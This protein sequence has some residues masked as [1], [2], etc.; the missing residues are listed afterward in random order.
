[1]RVFRPLGQAIAH[2]WPALVLVWVV[3]LVAVTML[4][5][6]WDSVV[7]DG[8][9]AF[10]PDDAPSLL[11]EGVYADAFSRNF[12]GS[13]IIVVARRD[14]RPQGLVEPADDPDHNDRQFIAEVLEPRLRALALENGWM[15]PEPDAPAANA[16]PDPDTDTAPNTEIAA[17]PVPLVDKI[18]SFTDPQYGPLLD[19]RD[20]KATLVRISLTTDYTEKVNAPLIEAVQRL[21][22]PAVE[23]SLRRAGQIPAG[24]DLYLSGPAV[25]GNDM[26]EAADESG[27]AT[28][29]ATVVLVVGLLI[30]IYRAPVLALI[31][32]ITVFVGVNIALHLLALLARLG[33]VNLFSGIEIYVTVVMYGAGVDYCMFLMARYKEEL[34]AGATF[35]EAIAESIH[36]VG[37]ALAASAGTTI[38]G[39]GMMV[40]AEFGKFRQAGVAMSLSLAVVLAA[41]LTF[42]PAL[43][44]LFGKWAFWPRIGRERPGRAAGWISPTRVM[45]RLLQTRLLRS[46]WDIVALRITRRPVFYLVTTAAVMAPLAVV[47]VVFHDRLTYGL[48]DELPP[49]RLSVLG[50]AAV[51]DHFPAGE[52]GPVTV[53]I[54]NRGFDFSATDSISEVGKL[55]NALWERREELGIAD[56]RSL[57]APFGVLRLEGL[58]ILRRRIMTNVAVQ[59][60]AYYVSDIGPD[61]THVTRLDIVLHDDPFSRNSIVH[62]D[63]L[64]DA[65]RQALPDDLE[66]SQLNFIGATASIR[67]LKTVTGRD[68]IRIDLL[69]MAGVFF[70]L[71]WLLR[72][73]AVAAYLIVTVFFSYLVTLGATFAVFWWLSPAE[74]AGLDWKVPLFLFT[75]L[76][77]VGEDYNIYLVTRV[78]EEQRRRGGVAGVTVGLARTGGIISSCGIIMAGTFGSLIFGTLAGMVQLGFALAFGVVLDTFIVRPILVPAWLVLVNNGTFGPVW[79]RRLGAIRAPAQVQPS[80]VQPPARTP[81][82]MLSAIRSPRKRKPVK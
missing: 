63:R 3:A 32:L 10:L 21:L 25:V 14:S 37:A 80:P 31:P 42:T 77:A 78:E 58:S 73:P 75:I 46:F 67:D 82:R 74:F 64:E 53:L 48:L 17:L 9:F 26:R 47:G 12:W 38:V 70:V 68:Q 27:S 28:E 41:S 13:S 2:Y 15:R 5:P 18:S 1:M 33:V 35:A 65:V 54:T 24:L 8:E 44:R 36:K 59:H 39:I 49:D 16:A 55:T 4:A 69:V 50:A 30:L 11:G 76:V 34:D 29:V 22:D 45:S 62:L 61:K 57:Y 20:G 71:V 56:I 7:E 6:S 72:Q 60:S 81:A 52:T 66:A 40:F 43:L 23:G 79:S 19:S 51:Q